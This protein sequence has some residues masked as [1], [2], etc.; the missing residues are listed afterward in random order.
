MTSP[1]TL[2]WATID[3]QGVPNRVSMYVAYDNLTE[4]VDA[5]INAWLSYGG[6]IDPCIDGK[7]TGGQ[8]LIPLEPDGSWKANP[9]SPGNNSNQ[10][11]TLNFNNNT[12]HFS[13]PI[14]L[15]SYKESI[16]LNKRPNIGAAPLSTLIA[17]ISAGYAGELF[18]NSQA[19]HDLTS[20]RNAYLPTHK[21]KKQKQQTI[22]FG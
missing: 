10:I 12:D 6:Q 18:P 9:V 19:L 1:T 22:V 15:P 5:I 13:S 16:L 8:I 2:E 21:L 11:M 14:Y 7:I 3:D 4:T 20:L 17:A